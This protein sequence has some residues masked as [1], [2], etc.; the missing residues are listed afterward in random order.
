MLRGAGHR[1][2]G[3]F[4]GA[5]LV[6]STGAARH[7]ARLCVPLRRAGRGQRTRGGGLRRKHAAAASGPRGRWF[8]AFLLRL[9]GKGAGEQ[10]VFSGFLDQHTRTQS[11][12]PGP[13]PR[14]RCTNVFRPGR[15][16]AE[17]QLVL[18]PSS[19]VHAHTDTSTQ[20]REPQV[21]VSKT[22]WRLTSRSQQ[23]TSDNTHR[24]LAGRGHDGV[25]TTTA[26]VPR[27]HATLRK[28]SG[29]VG[30]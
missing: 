27:E 24:R 12:T 2:K 18:F 10:A 28:G 4:P 8:V 13:E 11:A 26:H 17:W 1:L 7:C 19:P 29:E 23:R 5:A 25:V 14:L 21:H 30:S 16:H 6:A 3:R 20:R 15:A 22:R 9:A